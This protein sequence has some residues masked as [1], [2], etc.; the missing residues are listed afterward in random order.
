VDGP[1]YAVAVSP[2][3]E[4]VIAAGAPPGIVR[5]RRGADGWELGPIIERGVTTMGVAVRWSDGLTATASNA[6]IVA[7]W[8]AGGIHHWSADVAPTQPVASSV[9]FA[10]DGR[11][12]AAGY[13]DGMVRVWT[14][15]DRPIE[16][17]L[18]STSFATWVNAVDFSPDGAL[19]AAASSDGTVRF[20]DTESWREQR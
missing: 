17:T 16:H 9:A 4:Q 20:W 13:H 2:D 14:V 1:V 18:G 12:L 6:G 10:P 11:T 3:G 5:W 8:D 15:A 7:L 19:L